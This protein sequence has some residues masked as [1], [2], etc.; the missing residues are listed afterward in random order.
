MSVTGGMCKRH[1]LTNMS[2]ASGVN[3]CSRL[4]LEK[5]GIGGRIYQLPL[6][7]VVEHWTFAASEAVW[8]RLTSSW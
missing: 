4:K 6:N 2:R 3:L 7:L 1:N 5:A 8:H